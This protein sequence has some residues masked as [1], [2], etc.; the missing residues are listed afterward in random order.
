MA[1]GRV[2]S[3]EEDARSCPG[4]AG[5]LA[6]SSS[7]SARWWELPKKNTSKEHPGQLGGHGVWDPNQVEHPGGKAVGGGGGGGFGDVLRVRLVAPPVSPLPP[8][9]S[10]PWWLH[11]EPV[12][13]LV[14]G[15]DVDVFSARLLGGEAPSVDVV[16]TFLLL[17]RVGSFLLQLLPFVFRPP[18]LEPHFHLG[19]REMDTQSGV[20]VPQPGSK[21]SFPQRPAKKKSLSPQEHSTATLPCLSF[22]SVCG[23]VRWDKHRVLGAA[24]FQPWRNPRWVKDTQPPLK[25]GTNRH[26]GPSGQPD[27]HHPGVWDA[28][29]SAQNSGSS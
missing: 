2:S 10:S 3:A 6:A 23:K 22:P 20:M 13:A 12:P 4:T 17:I 29:Q 25:C 5:A 16:G 14:V 1:D 26:R 18:V 24:T 27:A 15:G 19:E 7:S 9:G 8:P 11:Q 28:S 21:L